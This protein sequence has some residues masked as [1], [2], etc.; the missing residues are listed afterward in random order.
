MIPP[1]ELLQLD[2]PVSSQQWDE[3]DC[4]LYALGIGAVTDP[5]DGRQLRFVDERSLAALPTMAVVLAYDRFWV[6][7][8]PTGIDVS[9]VL[10]AEQRLEI[11]RSLPPRGHALRRTRPTGVVDRGERG[12]QI[13]IEET[14]SD[15]QGGPAFATLTSSI[16]C[17]N[18]GGCGSTR[19]PAPRRKPVPQTAP[20]ITM[21]IHTMPQQAL[22]YRLSGDYNP[23]HMDPAFARRAGFE[24]PILHGLATFGMAGIALLGRFCDCRPERFRSLDMRFSGIVYP[25]E[26]IEL[27][28]WQTG[29]HEAMFRADVAGRGAVLDAGVFAWS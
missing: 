28:V 12:A 20:D 13:F 19:D 29:E 2:I 18:D 24:R 15:A 8:V 9:G 25:G 14:I 26:T 21:P 3:R 23:L 16:V 17:R 7:Q 27:S 10:H 22:L 6:E 1:S 4:A 11:H 5:L